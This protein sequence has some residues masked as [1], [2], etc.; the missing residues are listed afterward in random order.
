MFAQRRLV[1]SSLAWLWW[2]TSL[3]MEKSQIVC[4]DPKP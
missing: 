3:V 1:S 4:V 2:P